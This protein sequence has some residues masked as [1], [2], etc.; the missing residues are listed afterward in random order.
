MNGNPADQITNVLPPQA[1][2]L[3]NFDATGDLL[4]VVGCFSL[5]CSSVIF[6]TGVIFYQ[7]LTANKI[8][9]KL[10]MMLSLCDAMGSLGTMM[11][12]PSLSSACEAQ[13]ILIFFF[14]R[15]S[16]MWSTAISFS[17]YCQV[18]HGR[19]FVTFRTL[20]YFVWGLSILLEVLPIIFGLTY[21]NC[22][23]FAPSLPQATTFGT[24]AIDG[25]PGESIEQK[26]KQWMGLSF[27]FPLAI[28]LAIM[29]ICH[30]FINFRVVPS[31][32]SSGTDTSKRVL[33]CLRTAQVYPLLMLV[34][35]VPH[36]TAFLL[37]NNVPAM[38]DS[39]YLVI[40][41]SFAWGSLQGFWLFLL[42]FYRSQYSRVLWSLYIF[43][44]NSSYY[45]YQESHLHT[46]GRESQRTTVS[47]NSDSAKSTRSGA[48]SM[49]LDDDPL[50]ELRDGELIG[51]SRF[52]VDEQ[53][54][55]GTESTGTGIGSHNRSSTNAINRASMGA[56]FSLGE[57][58]GTVGTR[59]S[60]SSAHSSQS[61]LQRSGNWLSRVGIFGL[62]MSEG[63]ENAVEQLKRCDF[64][65][66]SM[67][68]TK[69]TDD[70]ASKDGEADGSNA[71]VPEPGPLSS[72]PSSTHSPIQGVEASRASVSVSVSKGRS[73]HLDM[74]VNNQDEPQE[75]N[76]HPI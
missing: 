65:D 69:P 54:S 43:G 53:D 12:Y 14:Y 62:H 8:Y 66:D 36:I 18:M 24:L 49:C 44:E 75:D 19:L 25:V 1:G 29:F 27:V 6:S 59:A 11:G 13:A 56:G 28:N 51:A 16:W 61:D 64:E 2:V 45:I 10:I 9:M 73:S 63:L 32:K 39:A 30:M 34:C 41:L 7:K 76:L 52:H 17:L 46:V 31:L 50:H 55:V 38:A 42:Y 26:F 58:R 21:G 71:S 5:L 67:Y 33:R 47:R 57:R 35:W 22:Y 72:P 70:W 3:E 40:V 48:N 74:G 4:Q 15:A 23:R 60:S 20:F 68:Y 37:V